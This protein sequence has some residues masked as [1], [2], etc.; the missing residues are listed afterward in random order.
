M[1][2]QFSILSLIILA[3]CVS[4]GQDTARAAAI[5]DT[6]GRT[7]GTPEY[8]QCL[9]RNVGYIQANRQETGA[10]I[11]ASLRAYGAAPRPV[12]TPARSTYRRPLQC[13]SYQNGTMLNTTC[14]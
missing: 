1:R 13:S 4:A 7:A 11:G 12:Y 5:C 2:F 14:Y 6:A 3:G 9:T 10:A 8:E